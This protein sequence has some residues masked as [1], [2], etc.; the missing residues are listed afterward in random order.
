MDSGVI[1]IAVVVVLF[2][3]WWTRKLIR[4]MVFTATDFT[5]ERYFWL[6]KTYHYSG[7]LTLA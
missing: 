2:C 4:R 5:V 7:D 6:T 3:L 1:F